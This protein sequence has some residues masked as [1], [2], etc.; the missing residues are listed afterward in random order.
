MKKII[1]TFIITILCF[2]SALSVPA[3][4]KSG[5]AASAPVSPQ[6][7]AKLFA[8]AAAYT[9]GNGVWIEWRTGIEN[10]ILGFHLYRLANG[11]KQLVSPILIP[12]NLS[13]RGEKTTPGKS[14]NYFDPQGALGGAYVIESID[15]GG[16]RQTSPQFYP[17]PVADLTERAGVSSQELQRRYAAMNPD[18]QTENLNLPSD[19]KAET[20]QTNN[21]VPADAS[22]TQKWVAAQPG[23]KIS[24]K[25]DG[26]YRVTR[27]ELQNAGFNV[28][29]PTANW[30]L[31][32]DG[33]E[34]SINVAANGDY[35]EFYGRGVNTLQTD[36]RVY[37]LVVGA[38]P[39]RRMATNFIRGISAKVGSASF[40]QSVFKKDR[41][42]YYNVILNG[43][44]ENFFGLPITTS[45]PSST[46]F[47]LP[48]VDFG[49]PTATVR[50][51]IQGFTFVAHQTR[52]VLNGTQIGTLTGVNR[53]VMT[54]T[55]TV[56][57][58]LL[59]SGNNTV[60]MTAMNPGGDTSFAQ[61]VEVI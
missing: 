2:S 47:T 12:G 39:G 42:S 13:P 36:A 4:K 59:V 1:S 22:A 25:Q 60:Q 38:Q 34:Q 56:P 7:G 41:V 30:Q 35:I 32:A 37:Y 5:L 8:S 31:Y 3:Q 48:D 61:S 10:E 28:N 50:I 33:I 21:A 54:A 11:E 16:N 24:V 53:D 55:F 9:D 44:A 15:V 51:A 23:A 26:L 49:A 20:A 18:V 19:L 46:N 17:Q 57:T 58:S 29:A 14:Y 27:A 43:D 52:V 6:E 45:S 40:S